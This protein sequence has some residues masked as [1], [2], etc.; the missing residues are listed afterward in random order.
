MELWFIAKY[1]DVFFTACVFRA[2]TP[3]LPML[4]AIKPR[5]SSNFVALNLLRI[6][7]VK[8]RRHFCFSLHFYRYCNLRTSETDRILDINVL[9]YFKRGFKL[10][11][12]GFLF[13]SLVTFVARVGNKICSVLSD[14]GVIVPITLREK[15]TRRNVVF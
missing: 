11:F 13:R 2:L 6:W 15:R 12:P 10:L 9:V 3:T 4:K 5:F 1:V 14:L 8:W 7:W